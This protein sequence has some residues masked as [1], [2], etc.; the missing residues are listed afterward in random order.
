MSNK[1][2][3]WYNPYLLYQ[4]VK[5]TLKLPF[6]LHHSYDLRL[7]ISSVLKLSV[8]KTVKLVKGLKRNTVII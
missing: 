8:T 5:L 7:R 3:P 2:V 6:F 4:V 1:D